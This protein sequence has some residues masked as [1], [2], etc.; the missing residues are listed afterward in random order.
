MTLLMTLMNLGRMWAASFSLWFLDQVM[1]CTALHCTVLY[2]TVQVTVRSCVPGPGVTWPPAQ[3]ESSCLGPEGVATC[4][5]A[6]GACHTLTEGGVN[7]R[8]V[9]EPSRSF[10]VP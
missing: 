5:E 6:G 3:G 2:C 10:T 1:Y 9:K 7:S 8:A 4:R